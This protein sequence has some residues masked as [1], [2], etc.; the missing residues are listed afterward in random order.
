ME[1][2]QCIPEK[3]GGSVLRIG[4]DQFSYIDFEEEP[5]L[6]QKQASPELW[7]GRSRHGRQGSRLPMH[8]AAG[9]RALEKR[10]QSRGKLLAEKTDRQPGAVRSK[11]SKTV[12]K[13]LESLTP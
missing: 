2:R 13:S 10:T 12:S 5:P 6:L 3:A 4:R 9:P 8:D 7:S 11:K 1:A